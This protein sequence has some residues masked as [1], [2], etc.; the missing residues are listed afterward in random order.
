MYS[1]NVRALKKPATPYQ[2]ESAGK[3][4]RLEHR[5][6]AIGVKSSRKRDEACCVHT[7][8]GLVV[9]CAFPPFWLWLSP[10]PGNSAQ[11]GRRGKRRNG[12]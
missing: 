5:N 4:E 11:T 2:Q 1:S 3:E 6:P 10:S 8:W 12:T 9:D 7:A